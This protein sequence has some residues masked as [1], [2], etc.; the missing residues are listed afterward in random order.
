MQLLRFVRVTTLIREMMSFSCSHESCAAHNESMR[1]CKRIQVGRPWLRSVYK[2]MLI[3]FIVR[4]YFDS[5]TRL[6][7]HMFLAFHSIWKWP[8]ASDENVKNASPKAFCL[9]RLLVTAVAAVTDTI[10][11]GDWFSWRRCTMTIFLATTWSDQSQ[12]LNLKAMIFLGYLENS[13]FIGAFLI[14]GVESATWHNVERIKGKK[15][16]LISNLKIMTNRYFALKWGE[17]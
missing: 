4:L 3:S 14:G 5:W 8:A 11:D 13:A 9:V 16:E 15:T 17:T 12:E 2:S 6:H 10:G 1:K 7:V